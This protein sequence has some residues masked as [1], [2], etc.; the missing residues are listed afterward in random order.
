MRALCVFRCRKRRTFPD[1]FHARARLGIKANGTPQHECAQ[2]VGFWCLCTISAAS[3]RVMQ[4]RPP[5]EVDT[6]VDFRIGTRRRS[7]C[8]PQDPATL[9]LRGLLGCICSF[10]SAGSAFS[11]TFGRMCLHATSLS[12]D[13]TRQDHM[14]WA[15][16]KK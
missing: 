4:A 10:G 1:R 7:Y 11:E 2:N 3:G 15:W 9:E 6:L 13:E 14:T 8:T 16:R 12:Y 5:A